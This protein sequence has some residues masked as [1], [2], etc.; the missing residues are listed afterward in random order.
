[1][2]TRQE[3]YQENKEKLK[4]YQRDYYKQVPYYENNKE[5]LLEYQKKYQRSID[6]TQHKT[7]QRNY[8]I[9]VKKPIITKSKMENVEEPETSEFICRIITSEEMPLIVEF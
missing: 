6:K 8:Y 3:Y 7:Y 5:A 1:M 9:K 2:K 4:Q